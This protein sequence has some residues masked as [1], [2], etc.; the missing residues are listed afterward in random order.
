MTSQI[1]TMSSP[2][3][4]F[5]FFLFFSNLYLRLNPRITNLF[6]EN[7]KILYTCNL[8]IFRVYIDL[9]F[10]LLGFLFI[11]MVSTKIGG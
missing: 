7:I 5:L 11:I 1:I 4:V 10:G 3:T 2:E 8:G 6:L 9:E